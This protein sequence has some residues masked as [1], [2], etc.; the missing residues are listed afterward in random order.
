MEK[1]KNELIK[2]I[3]YFGKAFL[4]IYS[5]MQVLLLILEQINVNQLSNAMFGNINEYLNQYVDPNK[6]ITYQGYSESIKRWI[7]SYT[8]IYRQTINDFTI[9]LIVALIL[10]AIIG[11]AFYL[12]H[13]KK[14]SFIIRTSTIGISTIAIAGIYESL[15]IQM[16]E[17]MSEY[18]YAIFDEMN[19]I[20]P[21]Y[22]L[23]LIV[24]VFGIIIYNH[25][26][27]EKKQVSK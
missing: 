14:N 23:V 26:K 22:S 21:K 12:T 3:K 15:I 7:S 2:L 4:C 17:N 6:S 24:I 16:I 1:V 20:F 13:N 11:I 18:H 27:K 9:I 5:T 25:Y 8:D 19:W 10:S